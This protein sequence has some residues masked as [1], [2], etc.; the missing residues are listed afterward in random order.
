MS[1]F[2]SFASN[3]EETKKLISGYSPEML[4]AFGVDLNTLFTILGFY[5]FLF[6]YI[7]FCGA[8]QATNMGISIISKENRNKTADFIL[9][10]PVP[11]SRVITGKLMA[12]LVS[13]LITNI[14]YLAVSILYANMLESAD[15]SQKSFI[16]ISL[17]LLLVQIMF[18]TIGVIIAVLTRKIKSVVSVSLSVVFGFYILGMLSSI[19]KED[20]VNYFTPFKYF[21]ANY[22][23]KNGAYDMPYAILFIAVVAVLTLSSLITYSKKDIHAV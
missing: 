12:I 21:D 9:T 16:L 6:I 7:L 22:I 2:P 1:V 19:I 18:A 15:Y 3:V 11:R 14:V 17:S 20:A 23:T 13:L 4:R 10:K 5:S 8:V